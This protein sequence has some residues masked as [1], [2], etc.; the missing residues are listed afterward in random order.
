MFEGNCGRGASQG[1]N[2]NVPLATSFASAV[3]TVCTG[4]SGI[5]IV[6]GDR[7][8]TAAAQL[9]LVHANTTH[10]HTHVVALERRVPQSGRPL[11]CA[12]QPVNKLSPHKT[13]I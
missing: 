6:A 9:K 5:S 13:V 10:R 2:L 7:T 12:G 4:S 8:R 11:T 3:S 1:Q